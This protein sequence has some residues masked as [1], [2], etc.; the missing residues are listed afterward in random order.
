MLPRMTHGGDAVDV[1]AISVNS[2]WWRLRVRRPAAVVT[3]NWRL[4]VKQK[5]ASLRVH[6]PREE[7]GLLF[8]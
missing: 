2:V 5:F 3:V 1:D 4:G 7:P 8:D 6:Q